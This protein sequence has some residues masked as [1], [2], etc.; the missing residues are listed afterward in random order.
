MKPLFSCLR[1]LGAATFVVLS[2]GGCDDPLDVHI[3]GTV[4]DASVNSASAADALRIGT[5]SS[6]NAIT[7]GGT[8]TFDRAWVDVGLF[9]DEWR[10]SG[11]QQ[12]Y[13]EI[14]SRAVPNTNT[15]LQNL[16]ANLHRAR[17]RAREAIDA[18]TKYKPNPPWGIGQMYIALALAELELAE[19]FCNG[20]PLSSSTNGAVVY[21]T[22][23]TNAQI[24]TL[25]GAH[26]D[27]AITFLGATDAATVSHLRLA[28]ILKARVLLDLGATGSGTAAAALVTAIPTSYAYQLTFVVGTG[29]NAIWA[30]NTSIKAA[31]VGDSVDA[32]GTLAGAVPFGSAGDPRVRATGSSVAPSSQGFGAD[33]GTPL[34]VQTVWGRSDAVN[35]ASGLDARLIEAE[36]RLQANDFTGMMTIL[37]GLRA[38]PP[39]I[40]G[41]YTP[42]VLPALPVPANRTAAVRLFFREKG[43]WTFGRGQRLGDLRRMIRQYGFTQDQVFPSGRFFKG[44]NYGTQVNLDVSSAELNN[45]NFT[46]C[47]DRNA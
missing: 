26:L 34:V 24:F 12:Q 28:Q 11:P 15:N 1:A 16:Y 33:G 3:V 43:F 25:A 46:A 10:T 32:L 4:T 5:L 31:S 39:A 30:A 6:V 36:A 9:T 42:A 29:D 27:T 47:I 37:N 38:A 19:Y 8:G 18:L 14:D 7:A 13:G 17:A 20:V 41:T 44:G 21:G 2:A 45:P 35:L 23:Q 40:H 22:P